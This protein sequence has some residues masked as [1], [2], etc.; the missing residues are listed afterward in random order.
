MDQLWVKYS[1]GKFG[2]SV[3][4]RIWESVGGKL[5]A[6]HEIALKFGSKIGWYI[7]DNWIDK[8]ELKFTIDNANEGHL[9]SVYS[10]GLYSN[11]YYN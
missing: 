6:E 11:S 8:D 9:P 10:T 1:E 2:F 3:Q 7:N 4:K 5:N